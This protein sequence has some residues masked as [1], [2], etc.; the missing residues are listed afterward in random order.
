[1]AKSQGV[2]IH[3]WYSGLHTNR[4]ATNTPVRRTLGGAIALND[5]LI[6]GLNM[7]ITPANTLARRPGWPKYC[8]TSFS[9]DVPKTFAGCNL[10]GNLFKI[11][12]TDKHVS[13]FDTTSITNILSK[14]STAVQTAFK[15]V[16]N[17]L[18]FSDGAENKKWT[19]YSDNGSTLAVPT[20]NGIV[21][22][23]SAPTISNLNLYD[24]V[25]ATQYPHAWI[26]GYTYANTTS[27]AENFF[28][29][30][31]TGEI[32]WAV[33]AR[34]TTLTSAKAAPNWAANYGIFGATTVDGG[35]LW[36]NCGTVGTWAAN[37]AF[38][39]AS[40]IATHPLSATSAQATMSTS[41][42]TSYNWVTTVTATNPS[43]TAAGFY[44]A[45]P[46][47]GNTNTLLIKALGFNVP[48]GATI[49]GIEV[50][51]YRRTNTINGVNDVT[52]KLLKAG[53][54]TGSNKATSGFWPVV[55]APNLDPF[56]P[57]FPYLPDMNIQGTGGVE[58]VYGG[59]SD[60]WGTTWTPAEVN[61]AGFGFE[62][63]ANVASTSPTT[64]GITFPNG[65]AQTPVL[66]TVY[67]IAAAS[68]ISGTVYAQVITDSNNNLQRV[69]T[70]GTS[71]G[72]APSWSTTIGGTTTDSGV[73]WECL[74]TANQL[75]VLFNWS[76]AYGYHTADVDSAH[77]ST[78][79]PLL[80]VTAPIIG[81][82]VTLGG[83]GSSDTTQCDRS[84]LYRTSDGGSLL[85]YDTSTPNV[86]GAV[87]WT[88]TATDQD[89][90]F[91]L[92]G[93]V[94]HANDPPPSGI[95][96]LEYHQGRLWALSGA[97]LFFS[98]GPDCINGDGA[99]AWPPA[100]EFT[101]ESAGTALAST[102]L[103][104]VVWTADGEHIVL[105]GPQTQTFWL[106]DL[107]TDR[108]V[109]SQ[110]CVA[111]DGDR[112][113][114]YTTNR[115]LFMQDPTNEEEIGFA[116]APTIAST[117]APLTTYVTTHR[118][119]QD[120]GIFLS[121]GSTNT[122]RYNLNAQSWDVLA[123]PVA[124][125][126]PLASIQTALG[127]KTLMSTAGGFIVNRSPSTF[128]DSGS[129]YTGFATVGSIVLSEPG[130]PPASLGKGVLVT[131]TTAGSTP[132]VSVL[133]NEIS[134]S[135]S[136]LPNPVADPP[137]LPATSTVNSK[138]WPWM[139]N[140]GPTPN[141]IKHLQVKV[142]IPSEAAKNEIYSL[143]LV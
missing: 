58:Q 14:A 16:G 49:L 116:V 121:D 75:P 128:Q 17:V 42:S 142:A 81:T 138:L 73:T 37:T 5:T 117:F 15:Q 67:Y 63:V 56:G 95:T 35:M 119:G 87:S 57:A 123:T 21:A 18:F 26:A 3:Q 53:V 1:M 124:G 85:L 54:A 74:G 24:T 32:Q 126:G 134:G 43:G 118:S 45:N 135:F 122:M 30:A 89:L 33:I 140:T 86:N 70:A 25:G 29:M 11:L 131:Y 143:G 139:G 93:P 141:W 92:I 51:V 71:G 7:E 100:N 65:N 80:T 20:N 90:N 133:P 113:I 36:T 39:N 6:D 127:T 31:P 72:S 68:D 69:K 104:L 78:M 109:L 9:T 40:Y 27:A 110:N 19:G 96:A 88:D 23:T 106:K 105:G 46:T 38:K 66:V 61:D 98:A 59:R 115:Q 112:L 130:A 62:M 84:D 79:S 64:G 41:G 22:P 94:A 108:G 55:A 50:D 137:E 120:Q 83:T 129:S 82:G 44:K 28:F 47:T 101:L 91:E 52:V 97:S 99:Q 125:I 136:T 8:S 2:H 114:I 13:I 102:S 4:A 12:D 111:Q 76:Y 132:T 34:G 103:G 48:A 60:L 107:N 77:I 10:N